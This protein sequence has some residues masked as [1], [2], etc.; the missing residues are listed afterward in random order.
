MAFTHPSCLLSS[1]DFVERTYQS[2]DPEGCTYQSSDPEGC[3]YQSS[4]LEGCTY[5]SSA[6][7]PENLNVNSLIPL[8]NESSNRFERPT[9]KNQCRRRLAYA[10][11]RRSGMRGRRPARIHERKRGIVADGGLRGRANNGEERR[12]RAAVRGRKTKRGATAA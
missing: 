10:A 1:S 5:Q 7:E 12:G 9:K 3:T 2:R 4:A 8:R 11:G 6:P